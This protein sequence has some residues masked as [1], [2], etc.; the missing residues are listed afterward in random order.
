MDFYANPPTTRADMIEYLKSWLHPVPDGEQ[1]DCKYN[2]ELFQLTHGFRRAMCIHQAF[3]HLNTGA[4]AFHVHPSEDWDGSCEPNMGMYDT[5]EDMIHGVADR[6]V[7]LWK[8]EK[9]WPCGGAGSTPA[10]DRPDSS[11]AEQ[12]AGPE[13]AGAGPQQNM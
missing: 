11:N 8:L 4:Y 2:D 5:F 10:D 13:L 6:Y 3:K 1:F 7:V 9:I 12:I